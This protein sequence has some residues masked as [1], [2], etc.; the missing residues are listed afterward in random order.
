MK[1]IRYIMK[2]LENVASFIGEQ[3]NQ[4]PTREENRKASSTNRN[5]GNFFLD[6]KKSRLE[7][8]KEKIKPKEI[9][10]HK[11]SGYKGKGQINR[12]S[13]TFNQPRKGLFPGR[14]H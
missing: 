13:A 5:T 4:T 11:G 8:K 6:M 3:I 1:I 14:N 10:S 7:A 9:Y 2:R 12:D